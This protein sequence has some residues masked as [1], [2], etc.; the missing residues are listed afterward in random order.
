VFVLESISVADSGGGVATPLPVLVF[1]S[2]SVADG[3]GSVAA[4]LPLLVLESI[5][6]ND[7][8]VLP[9]AV[10][11]VVQ[12]PIS[13]ADASSAAVPDTT[14]PVVTVPTSIIVDA[15]GPGGAVVVF[16][17]TATDPDDGALPPTCAPASGS[18]FPIGAT[19]VA[20]RS[21]DT[22]GNLGT[23]TFVVT[24]L[25]PVQSLANLIGAAI[26]AGMQQFVSVLQN[27]TLSINRNNVSAACGQLTAFGNQVSAQ[28]ATRLTP[29]QAADLLRHA[30]NITSTLGCR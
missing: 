7:N 26:A 25:T 22:H 19:T 18:V 10:A 9:P 21:S 23:A 6:V 3:S 12:E 28:S 30:R 27:A 11:L 5:S 29:A 1:E 17:A 13:V 14:P 20:C 16:A 4:P 8:P 24:V 15:T 2:V